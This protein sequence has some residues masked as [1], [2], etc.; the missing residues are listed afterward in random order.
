MKVFW[1]TASST[2][3]FFIAVGAASQLSPDCDEPV[4]TRMTKAQ[5]PVAMKCQSR[6]VT[7]AKAAYYPAV[8]CPVH[9]RCAVAV[10]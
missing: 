7:V 2:G 4:T 5:L 1:S 8:F 3:G 9:H 10:A 6:P